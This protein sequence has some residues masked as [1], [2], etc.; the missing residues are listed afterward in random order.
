MK[1]EIFRKRQIFSHKRYIFFIAI[2][3][4]VFAV[5]AQEYVVKTSG[6]EGVWTR[7]IAIDP[8]NYDVYISA[9]DGGF[10][11]STDQGD[12][13]IRKTGK[14]NYGAEAMIIA[15]WGDIFIGTS[16]IYKSSDDANSWQDASNGLPVSTNVLSLLFNPS[17]NEILAGTAYN[18]I[19]ISSDSGATWVQKNT[20]ITNYSGVRI[21]GLFRH[22]NGDI[23][24]AGYA[25]SGHIYRSTNGGESWAVISD[26]IITDKTFYDV[27]V[28]SNSNIF[29]V[30]WNDGLVYRSN[31]NGITWEDR[32]QGMPT[33]ENNRRI[34]VLPADVLLVGKTSE[35]VYRSDNLAV[36]WTKIPESEI[37]GRIGHEN[38]GI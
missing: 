24:A 7:T 14:R 27:K 12:S 4:C 36:S 20:G 11:Q 38:G 28:T 25:S 32:S 5:Q 19:Y 8:R 23:Y 10:Y 22:T 6:P 3:V 18:G 33:G 26:N 17:T 1:N 37:F 13:W 30:T 35:G 16:G 9:Q 21:Y 34:V 15:P 2:L 31:D 29:A